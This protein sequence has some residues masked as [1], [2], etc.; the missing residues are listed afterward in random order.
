MNMIDFEGKRILVR[1][2]TTDK[3]KD[4]EIIIGNT[5]EADVNHNFFLQESGGREDSRWRGDS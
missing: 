3:G 4:K 2:N 1:P 5:R